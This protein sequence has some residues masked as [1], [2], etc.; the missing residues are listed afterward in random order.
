MVKE[1][2]IYVPDQVYNR[3]RRIEEQWN[4]AIGDIILRAIVKV[5][6]EFEKEGKGGR[7]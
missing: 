7:S 5:I 2:R 6:E 1:I 4:I 3:L